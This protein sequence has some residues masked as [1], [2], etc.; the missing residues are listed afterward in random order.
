MVDAHVTVFATQHCSKFDA[1]AQIRCILLRS[2]SY[3]HFSMAFLLLAGQRDVF[4]VAFSLVP[5]GRFHVQDF[6]TCR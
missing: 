6:G 3:S 4:F 2:V 5:A 1:L